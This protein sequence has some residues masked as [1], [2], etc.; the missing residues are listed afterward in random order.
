MLS[1]LLSRGSTSSKNVEL[2]FGIVAFRAGNH[3]KNSIA[4]VKFIIVEMTES[5]CRLLKVLP[6]FRAFTKRDNI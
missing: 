2:S 5:N 6:L 4:Q 3:F 1:K